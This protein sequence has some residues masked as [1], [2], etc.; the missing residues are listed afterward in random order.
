MLRSAGDK[1]AHIH[2]A[3]SYNFTASSADCAT[4]STPPGTP[5][6]IHQHLDIGQGEVPWDELFAT[7]RKLDF[8]GIVTVAVFA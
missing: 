3:D 2:I 7:L 4:S 6:H 1:L 5:A 8:D